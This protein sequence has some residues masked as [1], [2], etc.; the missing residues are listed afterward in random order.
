MAYHYFTE[1][2]KDIIAMIKKWAD[3]EIRPYTGEWDEKGICP[4]DV[5]R[6]GL[7]IGLQS[8]DYPEEYGGCGLSIETA[9]A[10]LE[11][12]AKAD[13]GV[14]CAYSVTGTAMAPIMEFG[15]EEQKQMCADLI[16]RKGGL[17]SFCLTE[18]GSGSDSGACRMTAVKEGD[19]YILNGTKSFITN[20]GYADVYFV[21]ASTD[22]SKKNKGLSGFIVTRG[23]PGLRIGKEENKCGFRTSNTVELIFDNVVVPETNLV[24]KE[25][26]GFKQAMIA[27][28]HGRPFIG[29]AALGVAQRALEEAIA[30]SKTRVQFGQPICNNQGIRFMLA[31]M[32]IKTEAARC[33]VYHVAQLMDRKEKMTMNGSIAKCF[34]TD[35]AVHVTIDAVQIFGGYGYTKEY[36]VE[37]LMRDAKIFQIVEGTN[38]IQRVVISGQLL[39]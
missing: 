39:K 18:A 16:F 8:M 20:G 19:K 24:G 5:I 26:D 28:D 9:C 23:T 14:A 37:K 13:A 27:L 12:V 22:R 34:A 32:E 11:E 17:A 25:G 29:A 38:Q 36:P 7:R 30:Y 33:L 2:Q 4:M 21:V 35:A 1:E 15:T 6:S 3:K 31:D 10:V